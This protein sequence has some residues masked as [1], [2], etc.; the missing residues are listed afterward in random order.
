MMKY[1]TAKEMFQII[2]SILIYRPSSLPAISIKCG[3]R[4]EDR[5]VR[6]SVTGSTSA[7]CVLAKGYRLPHLKA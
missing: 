1:K 3:L 5:S 4:R 7:G 6:E 2:S